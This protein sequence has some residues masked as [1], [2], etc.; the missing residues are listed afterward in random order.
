MMGGRPFA[1]IFSL[2][3]EGC[4]S[5]QPEPRIILVGL[6]IVVRAIAYVALSSFHIFVIC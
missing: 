1:I 6:H 4:F 3:Q 2:F 5:K